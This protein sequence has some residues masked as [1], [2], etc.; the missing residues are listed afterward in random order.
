MPNVIQANYANLESLVKTVDSHGDSTSS[1]HN[2]ISRMVDRLQNGAWIGAGANAFYGEMEQD[3]FPA[4]K[5]LI[6]AFDSASSALPRII[7]TFRDAE[8]EARKLF[9]GASDGILASGKAGG[10]GLAKIGGAGGDGYA[11]VAYQRGSSG[12]F[13]IAPGVTY[14]PT[15]GAYGFGTLTISDPELLRQLGFPLVGNATIDIFVPNGVPITGPTIGPWHGGSTG[16]P[17][18]DFGVQT[19]GG[20][21]FGADPLTVMTNTDY[22]G[23]WSDTGVTSQSQV[24]VGDINGQYGNDLMLRNLAGRWAAMNGGGNYM[25]VPTNANG[26]FWSRDS[27]DTAYYAAQNMQ[28]AADVWFSSTGPYPGPGTSPATDFTGAAIDSVG[29]INQW[30]AYASVMVNSDRLNDSL[31]G[32]TTP[33]GNLTVNFQTFTPDGTAGSQPDH[34]VRAS[35]TFEQGVTM[36]RF[37]ETGYNNMVVTSYYAG[38][39]FMLADVSEAGAG[40]SNVGDV[41]P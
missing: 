12:S 34:T 1:L 37:D 15:G 29:V 11:R 7:K 25:V 13:E 18:G 16:N 23:S 14:N 21:T 26:D 17:Y 8:E 20:P 10:E 2:Q 4:L 40:Q 31:N 35:I 33:N 27:Y 28:F 38:G 5:R 36:A 6:G 24:N 19:L 22:A 39:G 30:L 41:N 3:V 9:E 32:F